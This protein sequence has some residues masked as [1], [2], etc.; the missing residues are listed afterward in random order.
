MGS[1]DK[2]EKMLLARGEQTLGKQRTQKKKKEIARVRS[3]LERCG[4]TE[5]SRIQAQ[6]HNNNK[7]DHESDQPMKSEFVGE[8]ER[9]T[10]QHVTRKQTIISMSVACNDVQRIK[11]CKNNTSTPFKRDTTRSSIHLKKKRMMPHTGCA[12]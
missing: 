4:T 3:T 6:T 8:R 11:S 2:I 9:E 1:I 12:R 5:A 10:K 7:N